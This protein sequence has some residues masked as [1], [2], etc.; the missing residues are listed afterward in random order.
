MKLKVITYNIWH[1]KYLEK[2]LD[3]LQA[4][5]PDVIQL[6]EVG[7]VGRG[8]KV[9]DTLNIF[10]TVK[11]KLGM[12]GEFRRMFWGNQGEG[13]YDMGVATLTNFPV[14]EVVDFYYERPVTQ[15]ELDAAVKDRY[16]LPRVLLGLKL[17]LADIPLWFFNTHFTITPNASVTERQLESVAQVRGYLNQYDDYVLTGDMNTPYKTTTY[18]RL[19]ED[20]S[21]ISKPQEP[22]LHPIIHTVGHLGYHV[23]YVLYKSKRVRCS[24]TRVP[25]V[26]GSDH[27]P[28]VV[29][30]E[31][32]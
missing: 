14:A 16:W 4:E 7:T 6:Q 28:V 31:V 20:L 24:K 23:D 21:D 26:D 32:M 22:T 5:K 10:E 2:V 13:R 12:Q 11:Q 15:L 1:G 27:L 3:F 8:F 29:E 19:V 25:L 17:K 18:E 9:E 30:L